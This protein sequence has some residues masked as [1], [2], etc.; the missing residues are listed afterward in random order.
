MTSGP[1]QGRPGATLRTGAEL[2]V[3]CDNCFDLVEYR[4]FQVIVE[5]FD[6]QGERK[7]EDLLRLCMGC[8]AALRIVL[9]LNKDRS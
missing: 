6:R 9:R 2:D 1:V 3:H 8:G 4:P 7:H 5:R